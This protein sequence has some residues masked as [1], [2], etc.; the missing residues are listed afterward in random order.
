VRLIETSQLKTWAGS[1]PAESRFPYTVKALICAVIQPDKLRLPSG[2]AVWLPGFDGVVVNGEENRFVP[3]GLSVW[4]LGTNADY[5]DKA[6]KDY[7]KRSQ[8]KTEEDEEGKV[9]PKVDRTQTTFVFVAPLVWMDKDDW[10]AER[11]ADLTWKDV[12]VI[13][14]V[15]LQDWLETA[16]AVSLQFAAELGIVPEAGLQSPDQAWEEWSY[17]TDPPSSEEL[18]VADREEQEKELIGRL[19]APHGTFTVRGD[20]PREA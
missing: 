17:L 20:S 18:V 12:V 16:P 8:D 9:A 15:D 7:E 14:G 3:T 11:K 6:N 13:D 2:D 10:V 4:E 1:K 19:I 5:R